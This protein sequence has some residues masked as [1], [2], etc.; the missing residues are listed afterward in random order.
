MNGSHGQIVIVL[1]EGDLGRGEDNAAVAIH[2]NAEGKTS[3]WKLATSM[4]VHRVGI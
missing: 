2:G 1:V 4:I 3:Q